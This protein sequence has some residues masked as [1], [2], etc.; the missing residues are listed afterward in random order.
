[1]PSRGPS[2]RYTLNPDQVRAITS[3]PESLA[4]AICVKVPLFLGF[5]VGELVHLNASWNATMG[6]IRVPASMWCPCS[7][8]AKRKSNGEWKPKTKAGVRVLPIVKPLTPALVLGSNPAN[9]SGQCYR[10]K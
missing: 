6:E 8:C 2:H 10:R 3:A 4:E 5:R 9:T 7:D 1:M